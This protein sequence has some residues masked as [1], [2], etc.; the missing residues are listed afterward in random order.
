VGA[1]ETDEPKHI[2]ELLLPADQRLGRHHDAPPSV[3][4]RE[5]GVGPFEQ[6]AL[7][8][9]SHRFQRAEEP[10]LDIRVVADGNPPAARRLSHG[11]RLKAPASAS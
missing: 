2:G 4:G 9:A 1:V 10:E 11:K 6:G 3:H 7:L 5:C 8:A